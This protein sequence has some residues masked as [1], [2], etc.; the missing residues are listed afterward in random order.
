MGGVGVNEYLISVLA[1]STR[2]RT[3]VYGCGRGLRGRVGVELCACD[4]HVHVHLAW[5]GGVG[6]VSVGGVE[7]FGPCGEE[8]AVT[9]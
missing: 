8:S 9:V 2:V 4:I 1:H 7:Q 6:W 3:T 5:L